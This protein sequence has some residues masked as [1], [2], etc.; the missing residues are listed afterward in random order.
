MVLD[1]KLDSGQYIFRPRALV[2][3]RGV[4]VS[5]KSHISQSIL[6]SAED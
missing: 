5:G 2:R 1:E 4:G 6:R 3:Q